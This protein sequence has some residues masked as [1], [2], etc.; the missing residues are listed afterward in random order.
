ME[1]IVKISEEEKQAYGLMFLNQLNE[2]ANRYA[3]V[4]NKKEL[5]FLLDEYKKQVKEVSR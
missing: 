3:R 2:L 5:D 1:I 4:F